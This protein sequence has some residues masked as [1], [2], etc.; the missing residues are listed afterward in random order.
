MTCWK[1]RTQPNMN[2]TFPPPTF[3]SIPLVSSTPSPQ[4]PLTLWWFNTFTNQ[5]TQQ[6][7]N[8]Q[9]F[10]PLSRCQ[11]KTACGRFGLRQ[12]RN[13]QDRHAF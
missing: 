11:L 9:I 8:T 1:K 10:S 3:T 13:W 2:L 6:Y 5:D 7:A 4:T 12:L